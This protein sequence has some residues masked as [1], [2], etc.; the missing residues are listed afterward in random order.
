M[1][2]DNH[3]F[4]L[5]ERIYFINYLLYLNSA[6]FLSINNELYLK[7]YY[8]FFKTPA[9]S[10]KFKNNGYH[11]P[12]NKKI[13]NKFNNFLPSYNLNKNSN[14]ESFSSFDSSMN[15]IEQTNLIKINWTLSNLFFLFNYSVFNVKF[16]KNHNLS[17]FSITTSK[18]KIIV[19]NSQK[20]INRWKSSYDFMF[21]IF[22][23]DLNFTIFSSPVFKKETLSVNWSSISWSLSL[24]KYY[25]PFFIFQPNRYNKKIEFFF[26]KL[27]QIDISFF[28]VT[29]CLYHYKNLFYLKKNNSFTLGLIN[30]YDNPWIV[31][32]PIISF[33]DNYLIQ[34]FF[35]KIIIYLQKQAIFFKFLNFKKTW[36]QLQL[37]ALINLN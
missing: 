24:W 8:I 2:F 26:K 12:M 15:K 30:F 31:S 37:S 28:I 21:N 22:Y 33:F 35:F 19:I 14:W 27:K 1:F 23:F 13:F 34:S 20:L 5:N 32:Y 9:L 7:L 6:L 36:K 29:D 4:K 10:K 17:F 25:S 16:K 3:K 11:A 18:E